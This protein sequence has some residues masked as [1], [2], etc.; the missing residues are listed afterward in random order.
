MKVTNYP[1]WALD[2]KKPGTELRLIRGKYFLYEYKTVYDQ[3][4]KGPRKISGKLLGSVTEKGFVPS[5]TRML[6]KQTVNQIES[7]PG[8]REY[9]VS[10][11]VYKGFEKYLSAL[12][13]FFP[14]CWKQLVVI[15]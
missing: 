8:C 9:G 7:K 4:R 13:K 12:E 5:K 11:L 6:E 2:Q 3:S 15:A 14:L 10:L 1:Q